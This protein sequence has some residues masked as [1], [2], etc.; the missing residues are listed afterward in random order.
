MAWSGIASASVDISQ[1]WWYS[2][3]GNFTG[4][5]QDANHYEMLQSYI[6]KITAI[7]FDQYGILIQ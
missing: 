4:S 3:E 6:F 1:V 7:L 2:P 5:C